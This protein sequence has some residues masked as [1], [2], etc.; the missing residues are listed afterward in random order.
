MPA[1]EGTP[2]RIAWGRSRVWLPTAAEAGAIDRAARDAAGVPER[3]LMENAG[4]S[5]ALLLAHAFP[6]GPVVA[7]VGS[8]SN[9]GD[10]LV[11]LR[12]LKAWGRQVAWA[13]TADA[14]PEPAL[15]HGFDLPRVALSDPALGRAAVLVDGILGTGARGAPRPAARAAIEA[16]NGAG[17]PVVALDLPTGVDPDTGAIPGLAESQAP[18]A[19]SV[20]ADLTVCFG[21]PK[22]GL[23]RAPGRARCG[24]LVA[25]EIG[26]PP[27]ERPA[28]AEAITP[29]WAET[30]LPPRPFGTHKYEAGSLLVCAGRPGM[31][32]AAILAARSAVRVGTGLVRVV[33]PEP[34]R[35]AIQEAVPDALYVPREDAGAVREAVAASD[36][37]VV[38]PALGPGPQD[39]AF[40]RDVLGAAPALPAVLDADA[41]TL[42][43]AGAARTG[44]LAAGR[45]IVL[46]PHPGEFRRLLGE[47]ADEAVPDPVRAAGE[48]A[49]ASGATV[50]L[51]GAPSVVAHPGEPVLVDAG[52][53][54]DFAKAGMGD[55][56]AGLIGG[57]LAQGAAPRD[58]A[59]VALAL[60]GAAAARL[61]LSR[62][63]S[64]ADLAEAIAAVLGA[65]AAGGAPPAFPFLVFD[66]PAP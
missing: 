5:A 56:L 6:D 49:E 43:G 59:G 48:F 30:R 53:S 37:L 42:I 18:E 28:G 24:R 23:L 54:A 66:Q 7:V 44:E 36:A 57:L 52:G 8:G 25:V 46:T 4:R 1:R 41:L 51:K 2:P 38:G 16:V 32:G 12:S 34:N 17:R 62:G 27:A 63:L 60:S 64:P 39:A 21:W 14:V 31:A 55:H 13:A 11:L 65:P 40:L 29:Q 45:Q 19:A 26:F 47:D 3:V 33:S 9:G 50:L 10:A 20:R 58:A 22:R 15:A 61:G 35:A